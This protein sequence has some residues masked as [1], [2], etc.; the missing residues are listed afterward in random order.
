M[1]IPKHSGLRFLILI[2]SFLQAVILNEKYFIL[3]FTSLTDSSL[4]LPLR[5]VVY[6]NQIISSLL[7]ANSA[8]K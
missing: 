5:F 8:L 2:F 6:V 7:G 3:I 1:L 4:L